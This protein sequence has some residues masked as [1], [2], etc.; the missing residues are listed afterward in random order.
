MFVYA[1]FQIYRVFV[2]ASD[3]GS[4]A[5][6][7]YQQLIVRVDRDPPRLPAVSNVYIGRNHPLQT[8]IFQV[9]ATVSILNNLMESFACVA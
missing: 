2:K 4:P 7:T 3:G 8:Q 6:F 5:K 1:L 9:I